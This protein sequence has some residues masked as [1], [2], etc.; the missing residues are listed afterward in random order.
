MN[1]L[2]NE[3][4]AMLIPG[5]IIEDVSREESCTDPTMNRYQV[6]GIAKDSKGV[7]VVVYQA[8]FDERETCTCP[9]QEFLG[10]V[11][12]KTL[13]GKP[14]V[15]PKFKLCKEVVEVSQNLIT[16]GMKDS[17]VSDL[18][19]EIEIL[20]KEVKHMS[21]DLKKVQKLTS[22]L[23]NVKQV[24]GTKK[25]APDL[26]P[27]P[28]IPVPFPKMPS[29]TIT[30]IVTCAVSPIDALEDLKNEAVA[31]IASNSPGMVEQTT[32]VKHMSRDTKMT[33]DS[34]LKNSDP[35]EGHRIRMIEEEK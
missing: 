30:P 15:T 6:C 26:A 32:E 1:Q 10:G 21:R 5:T 8:L 7:Y 23:K 27:M 9:I 2:N 12:T 24:K 17:S 28:T 34:A 18:L 13:L 29:P 19:K 14:Y 4:E 31:T 20:R 22:P 25:D 3:R 33:F 16:S 35:Q 11:E